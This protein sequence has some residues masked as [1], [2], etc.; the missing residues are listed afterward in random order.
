MLPKIIRLPTWPVKVLLTSGDIRGSAGVVLYGHRVARRNVD[1]VVTRLIDQG[2]LGLTAAG[3][4]G[5]IN[6]V[7]VV[8]TI[9]V[10][11]LLGLRARAIFFWLLVESVIG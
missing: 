9:G 11:V 3:N 6:P 7:L 10:L 2:G 1:T 4:V 8:P 5:L